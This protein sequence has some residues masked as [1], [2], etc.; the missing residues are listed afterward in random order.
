MRL[1]FFAA[2]VAASAAVSGAS[3]VFVYDTKEGCS[4]TP[5]QIFDVP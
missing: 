5:R 4:G 1:S 3:K 2:A